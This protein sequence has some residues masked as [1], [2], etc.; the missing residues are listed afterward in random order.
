MWS[1]GKRVAKYMSRVD[2]KNATANRHRKTSKL[3]VYF[4][5][6]APRCGGWR[7]RVTVYV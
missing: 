2:E 1:G 7:G 4:S 3:S 6:C 5:L